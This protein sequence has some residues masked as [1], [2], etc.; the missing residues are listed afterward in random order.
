MGD[1]AKAGRHLDCHISKMWDNN[2]TGEINYK[3]YTVETGSFWE[4]APMTSKFDVGRQIL[5]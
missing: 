1:E 2:D 4:D 5:T 3:A